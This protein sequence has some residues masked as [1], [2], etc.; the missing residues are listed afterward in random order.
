[1]ERYR[2]TDRDGVVGKVPPQAAD[3]GA[4]DQHVHIHL[5]ELYSQPGIHDRRP[6]DPRGRDQ[7]EAGEP[8]A[9][10]GPLLCTIRQNGQTGDW[11][12]VLNDGGGE[13]GAGTP[14]HIRSNSNG[15]EIYHSLPAE[16]ENGD[17]V[18]PDVVGK[19]PGTS[20]PGAAHDS[21]DRLAWLQMKRLG[22]ASNPSMEYAANRHLQATVNEFY[23]RRR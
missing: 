23:Q 8:Q 9:Q 21:A 15:L 20:S 10:Y 14:L 2:W 7:G 18:D 4:R 12:G 13:T 22:C 17:A 5:P 6:N 11:E 3:G 16:G 1:M 19:Y